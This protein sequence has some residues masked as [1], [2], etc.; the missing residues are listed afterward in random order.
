MGSDRETGPQADLFARNI[1][2]RK[3]IHAA[4]G[5]C[6]SDIPTPEFY[7]GAEATAVR[8]FG[9]AGYAV[10]GMLIL[11]A[12]AC[13]GLIHRNMRLVR[14]ASHM[15]ERRVEERTEE[16]R[17]MAAHDALTGLPNR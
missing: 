14:S 4:S 9:A 16:I 1:L 15:L 5:R 3:T 10:V 2:C 6:G 12:L 11:A 7:N 8:Y 17:H 13:W